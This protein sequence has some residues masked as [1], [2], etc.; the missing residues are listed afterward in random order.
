MNRRGFFAA[1]ATLP[2]APV[3]LKAESPSVDLKFGPLPK[4]LI[5][6]FRERALALSNEP[7]LLPS[8]WPPEML[9]ALRRDLKEARRMERFRA[10]A[11]MKTI[12]WT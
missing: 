9:E 8:P 7:R 10:H 5:D 6:K 12:E 11:A 2:L 1:L 4:R 3:A